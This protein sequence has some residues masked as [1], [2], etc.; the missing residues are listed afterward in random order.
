MR[1]G[2]KTIRLLQMAVQSA[3]RGE[4]VVLP[5][6]RAKRARQL[7]KTI[8]SIDAR[9]MVRGRWDSGKGSGW[10]FPYR[11]SWSMWVEIGGCVNGN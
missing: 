8:N 7:I 10:K 9:V 5:V 1:Q 3:R 11:T 6:R 2:G 4:T